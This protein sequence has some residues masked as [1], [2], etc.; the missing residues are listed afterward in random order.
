MYTYI[1]KKKICDCILSMI[2]CLYL[3]LIIICSST[4]VPINPCCSSSGQ[5]LAAWSSPR[6]VQPK[7]LIGRFTPAV[8]PNMASTQWRRKCHK[9]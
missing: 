1:Y 4:V 6:V 9:W 3:D 5:P 2:I 8:E 7:A